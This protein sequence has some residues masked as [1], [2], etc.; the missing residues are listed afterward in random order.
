MKVNQAVK[1]RRTI[2]PYTAALNVKGNLILVGLPLEE[3]SKYID[4]R[5]T[6]NYLIEKID[7]W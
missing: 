7:K 1:G 4:N 5:I 2:E 6:P 3:R